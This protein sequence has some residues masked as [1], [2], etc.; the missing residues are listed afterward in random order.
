MWASHTDNCFIYSYCSIPP[1]YCVCQENPHAG[2]SRYNPC[3]TELLG[4]CSASCL[5]VVS[6]LAQ[7]QSSLQRVT[8]FVLIQSKIIQISILFQWS[9][10]FFSPLLC[11]FCVILTFN[12]L[13]SIII[14]LCSLKVINPWHV[15][16]LKTVMR[17]WYFKFSVLHR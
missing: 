12:F 8:A 10:C 5:M 14:S 9:A 2:L 4:F 17:Q 6:N 16:C 13:L 15:C 1:P 11:K 7:G 3:Y